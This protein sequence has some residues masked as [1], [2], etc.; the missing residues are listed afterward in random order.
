MKSQIQR[1]DL[2]RNRS[3]V[4]HNEVHNH[5]EQQGAY[6]RDFTLGAIKSLADK[7][8]SEYGL[9]ITQRDIF[10]VLDGSV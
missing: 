10:K 6:P 5:L 7:L 8:S 3:E 1:M 4:I 2:L 9:E